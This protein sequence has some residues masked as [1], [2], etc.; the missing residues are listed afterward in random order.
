VNFADRITHANRL[1]VTT[2]RHD[3][4]GW[5]VGADIVIATHDTNGVALPPPVL[6]AT[7]RHEV[8]HALGLAHSRDRATI[9]YPEAETLSITG[10]D[11]ATLKLLYTLPPGSVK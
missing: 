8:G 6:A 9:M 7:A 11:R 5:I 10:R 3:H 2:H 4:E 1:G